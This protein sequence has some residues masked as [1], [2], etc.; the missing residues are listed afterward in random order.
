MDNICEIIRSMSETY[1]E[2]IFK[3]VGKTT[4][5]I[6]KTPNNIL[7]VSETSPKYRW[8]I[9]LNIYGIYL[10]I[11]ELRMT[12]L[13]TIYEQHLKVSRKQMTYE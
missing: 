9:V 11:S 10:E 6:W 8:Q 7:Y 4:G 13:W 2:S 1:I 5:I 3:I 12:N